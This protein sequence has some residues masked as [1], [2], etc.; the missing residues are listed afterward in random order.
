METTTSPQQTPTTT[1]PRIDEL[2]R[3]I[4][5]DV[6]I[7]RLEVEC[8]SEEG[9]SS[10]QALFDPKG[11]GLDSVEAL[12]I[13]AAVEGTYRISFQGLP[14]QEIRES[15]YSVRSLATFVDQVL[16]RQEAANSASPAPMAASV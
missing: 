16:T 13:M 4:K 15:F 6:L 9:I 3:F 2:M 11:L 7:G 14:E 10:D 5:E 12:E 8:E 1:S